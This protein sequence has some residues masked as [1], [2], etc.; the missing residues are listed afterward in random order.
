MDQVVVEYKSGP[1]LLVRFIWWLFVGWWASGIAIGIA[2]LAL[3]TIVGIP[4]GIWL[5]N[6]MPSILTL[7][8]RTRQRSVGQDT[9]GRTII[10]EGGRAQTAWPV[11]GLWFVLI[12]WWASGLWMVIAWLISITLIGLPLALLM[13]NRTPFVASLYRY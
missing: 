8:P 5:I 12:G 1:N 10:A 11:R 3:S 2:W 13:L 6:R 4:I 9:E 7:R